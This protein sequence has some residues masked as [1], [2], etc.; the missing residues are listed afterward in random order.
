MYF[1]ETILILLRQVVKCSYARTIKP[2]VVFFRQESV[3]Y[4]IVSADVVVALNFIKS[5][6]LSNF[7]SPLRDHLILMKQLVFMVMSKP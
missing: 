6:R 1:P 3:H 2:Y 5:A 7:C 4:N